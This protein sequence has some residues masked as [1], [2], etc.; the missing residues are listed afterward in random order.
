MMRDVCLTKNIKESYCEYH[1]KR[2]RPS[3]I[4]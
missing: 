3:F 1:I 2:K 4:R